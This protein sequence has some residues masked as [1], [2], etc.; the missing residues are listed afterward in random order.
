MVRCGWAES[1]DLMRAYHD[2]EWGVPSHDDTYL[3]E[4]ITLEG[5]QAGLSWATVLNKRTRYREVLDGFD[6]LVI[7]SYRAPKLAELLLDAGIIRHR[8][9][10]ASLVTNAAA[11]GEVQASHGS[12]ADY[13]WEWV[14]GTSIVNRPKPGEGL[15]PRTVLSDQLSKDLKRRGFRFVG[16][17]IIYSYLQ[18]VGLVNDHASNCSFRVT[19][20]R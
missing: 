19:E 2:A 16:S 7:A 3:F 1:T 12:F 13:L 6:P 10:I 11:F 4:L 15:P 20:G 8:L 17:T 14:G 5:A 18:A 9:K